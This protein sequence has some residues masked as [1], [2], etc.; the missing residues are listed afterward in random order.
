MLSKKLFLPH[1]STGD[2]LR[3]VMGSGMELGQKAKAYMDKG[4]LVPDNIILDIIRD[5]IGRPDCREGYLL[6]GFPRTLPQAEAL[7]AML[8]ANDNAIDVVL[9]IQVPL[10]LLLERLTGRRGCLQC[11]T[12]YHQLYSPTKTE[13]L[14]D[15]CG[16]SLYQRTDDCEASVQKRLE[17]YEVQTAPLIAYYEKRKTLQFIN[18]NQPAHAVMLELGQVLGL[19]W[20]KD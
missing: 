5:R 6:D 19:D 11:G 4:Q 17:V 16:G 8:A 7:D 14:C 18:G 13:G 20:E 2:M 10:E 1:I 15:A 12:I 3:A 9:N